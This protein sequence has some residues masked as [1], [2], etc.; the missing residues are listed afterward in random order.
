MPHGVFTCRRK[1]AKMRS[2]IA[3]LLAAGAAAQATVYSPWQKTDTACYVFSSNITTGC[4]AAGGAVFTVNNLPSCAL[5]GPSTQF[6]QC[7]H[8]SCFATSNATFTA[9][10]LGFKGFL[11]GSPY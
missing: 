1:T 7:N 10:C 2:G 4:A 8:Q 3:V 11:S 5:A 9:G 6:L